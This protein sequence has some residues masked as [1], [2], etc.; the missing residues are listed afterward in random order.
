MTEIPM[1]D[2]DKPTTMTAMAPAVPKKSA[3]INPAIEINVNNRR[4]ITISC[5]SFLS[6]ISLA[7]S[8]NLS[9]TEGACA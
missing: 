6:C 8:F 3:P 5:I 7:K 4:M 9:V 1:K 2:A